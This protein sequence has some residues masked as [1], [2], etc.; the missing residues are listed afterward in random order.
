MA[1]SDYVREYVIGNGE[2][3][4]AGR[5]GYI[6]KKDDSSFLGKLAYIGGST[7]AGLAGVFE[8]IGKTFGT[9]GAKFAGDER[10]ARYYSRK[11]T[12]G[13]W[14]SDLAEKYSPD[15]ITRFFGDAGAG[16]GQ[17]GGASAEG[18]RSYFSDPRRKIRCVES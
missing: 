16:V 1:R 8:G 10:L 5:S 17:S 7:V 6:R 9:I 11:S 14:Q 13:E 2:V 12:I 18:S 3:S 15:A 4:N